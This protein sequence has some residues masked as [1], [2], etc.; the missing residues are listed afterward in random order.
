LK[1]QVKRVIEIVLILMVIVGI[2]YEIDMIRMKNN[3]PVVFSTW[4]HS[5]T[6][7]VNLNEIVDEPNISGD[8]SEILPT[9]YSS[10][11]G[12][13]LEETTTYMIVEPNEDE[14][15]RKS[16]DKIVINY[17]TDNIDYLYGVGR[18]VLIKYTGYIMETY[19]SQINTKDISVEGYSEF[20]ILVKESEKLENKKILNNIDLYKNNSDYDLYYYGLDEVNVNVDNKTMSLEEALKS[21]R[22]T[23]DKII[24]NANNDLD[25]EIITGDMYKDGGSMMYKYDNFTIIKKHT[26]SGNRDMYI[27]IPE[28][29]M[30]D[31]NK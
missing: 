11:I 31:T 18:K 8:N 6:P 9:E 23:L 24:S 15:E 19:P 16:S 7:P 25:N 2:M 30:Q 22:I 5:Y 12:T 28:M 17:G 26:I 20:E 10:F 27:G 14:V 29:T 13:V 4:G 1:K 21:G 3:K